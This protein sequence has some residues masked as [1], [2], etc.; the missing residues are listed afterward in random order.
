[1]TILT[2]CRIGPSAT[3]VRLANFR[4]VPARLAGSWWSPYIAPWTTSC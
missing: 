4:R 2:D 3:S 1:M